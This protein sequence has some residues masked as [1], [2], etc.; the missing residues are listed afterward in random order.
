MPAPA[1]RVALSVLVRVEGEGAFAPLALDAEAREARLAPRDRRLATELVYGTLRWR[2][3]LDHLLAPFS[4]RPWS[5]LSPWVRNAL[6]L[7]A[8]QVLFLRSVPAAVAGDE[9]V[10]LVK[11]RERWA[12][13]FANAVF[14]AFLRGWEQ[15]SFPDPATEPVAYIAAWHSHPEWL[16]RRW[17][18]RFG[19]EACAALCS[20]NNAVPPLTLRVNLTRT[21]AGRLRAALEANGARV[22]PGRLVPE[23]LTVH[24]TGGVESLPGFAQGHFQVQDE[25]SQLVAWVVDPP[26]GGRTVD[27]CAAPGGK[28]T[29]LAERLLAAGGPDAGAAEPRIYAYD[30]HP[31][32]LGLIA[33]NARRL[34]VDG[35]IRLEARDAAAVTAEEVGHFERVLL[36]APC[37]GTGVLRRRPDLRWQKSTGEIASLVAAQRRLLAGAARLVAP[38]GALVYT[39]CSLEPEENEENAAWFLREHADF[40]PAPLR[41]LLPPPAGRHFTDE[42]FSLEGSALQLLPHVDGVDGFFIFRA[43][44]APR[45]DS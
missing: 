17:C 1:R 5:S 7:A 30:L 32:R 26:A 3:R 9:C 22:E 44:R 8:Y 18:A 28:A 2:G 31:R 4:S 38:G 13:G 6:R 12:A 11:E 20:A 33:Q 43:V 34:G 23:A 15:V 25:S 37:S 27:L 19:A 14:R 36:D 35:V 24:G 10:A 45:V 39:T 41:P 16:V 29:H 21:D 42:R 40:R